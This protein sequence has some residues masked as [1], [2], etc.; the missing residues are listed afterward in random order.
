MAI[1]A[2]I[3]DMDGTILDTMPDLAVAA[4]EAF[5]QM[6]LPARTHTELLSL[7]G[8]GGLYLIEHAVPPDTDPALVEQ[9]F[10]LWRTI[11]IASS[12]ENT[13][14]FPGVI[15]TLK[16]LRAKGVKTAVLSNKFDA[17]ARVLAERHFPGLFGIVR[18][19]VPPTPRKPDPTSLLHMLDE[20]GVKPNEAAYVGDT[21][22]DVATARNAGVMAVGVSW[23]YGKTTP[24]APNDLDAY[25]H[26][27]AELLALT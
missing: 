2:V 12:Y 8:N 1:K 13:V 18:G 17:G 24:L 14:P 27:P 16:E 25:I 5:A 20:L 9:T 26:T 23:G 3:Y 22:I 19:D 15:E 21:T 10:E 11:Y 4:N 7:M 6:G